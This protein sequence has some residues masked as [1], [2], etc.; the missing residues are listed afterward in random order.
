MRKI[1]LRRDGFVCTMKP[2]II[3]T[4][5]L[6][7]IST[8][9]IFAQPLCEFKP[10]SLNEGFFQSKVS[11]IIQDK[12]G[13]IW[14]GTRNGLMQFDGYRFRNYKSYP[15][16]KCPMTDYRL[17][18]I[19]ESAGG[20]I[21]CQSLDHRAYLFDVRIKKFCDVLKSVESEAKKHYKVTKIIPLKKGVTWI[22]CRGNVL[23]RVEDDLSKSGKGIIPQSGLKC[24]LRGDSI[25]GVTDDARGDEWI[26]T[27]QGIT[28]LGRKLFPVRIPFYFFL[29]TKQTIWLAS[30]K[31][32]LTRYNPVTEKL[33][34]VKLPSYVR[35]IYMLASLKSGM[36][37]I[38]TDAGLIELNP[39]T[40][41]YHCI[42]VKVNT[43]STNEVRT[44]YEDH[45]GDL[46]MFN[47]HP[48]ILHYRKSD[49]KV[50][51]LLPPVNERIKHCEPNSRIIIEDKQGI[52]WVTPKGGN[53]C[54][55]D[56]KE[57]TLKY[58]YA[59][60]ADPNSL[61]SPAIRANFFDKQGN[62]WLGANYSFGK[63][64]FYKRNYTLLPKEEDE[65]EIRTFLLDKNRKLWVASKNE[66]LKILDAN[67]RCLGYVS[68]NGTLSSTPCSFHTNVYAFLED[69]QGNI[70]LGTKNKGLYL[71]ERKT[72]D[73]YS[74]SVRH[75]MKDPADRFSLSDNKIYS[76]YQDCK[77]RIWI[78]TFRGGLNLIDREDGG[79]VRFIHSSNRLKNFPIHLA[80][81]VRSIMEVD[82]RVMLLGTM[83]GIVSFSSAFDKPE[84]IRYFV[85]SHRPDKITSL[86]NNN[87]MYMF[88]DSKK[89]I[90]ALTE[91][92]GVNKILSNNL[93]SDN[94]QFYNY[95]QKEGLI[96]DQTLSMI[97]DKAGKLWV[98]TKQA[99]Y[100][101]NPLKNEDNH[102]YN[103]TFNQDF[104]FSESSI[105][106]NAKGNVVVG[107]DKGVLE[108][109]SGKTKENIYVPPIVFTDLNIQGKPASEAIGKHNP[110]TLE[111][112]QRDIF[113]EFAALDY[114]DSKKI[115]YAY[116]MEGLDKGWHYVNQERS[117]T[118]MN[119]PHGEYK[120]LVKS[121]NSEGI[122]VDNVQNLTIRVKPTFWETGWAW[123][124]I[125][126]LIVAL[127]LIVVYILF[128][129]Y[130]LRHQV[131][132]E[133]QLSNIKLNFFTDI[134][135]ELRT[136]LTLIT[137]PVS[138]ILE[139]EPLSET[140]KEHLTI[141]RKNTDRML[142][143][144][145]Q[146][147]DFRK[148][149]YKKMKVLIEETDV[150]SFVSRIMDNFQLIAEEKKISFNLDSDREALYLWIDK[151]K[152]E[153][154]I[155]NL[156]SNAFKYTP[157][158]KSVTVRI[159]TQ[160]N[161]VS[162]SIIDEGVGILAQK[163]DSLFQRFETLV[164]QSVLH[165]SSG[166]G[167]A[168][169]KE[170]VELHHGSIEVVSQPGIGSEFKVMFL[171]G[172][173]QFDEDEE[174]NFILSDNKHSDIQQTNNPYEER[175]L[176]QM[177]SPEYS[178]VREPENNK[179]KWTILIVED[180]PELLRFMKNILSKEYNI[181][182]AINGQD[183]IE[184]ILTFMPDIVVSDV[185][186]PVMDGLDMVKAVKENKDLCHIPIIL[187]SAKS[188]LDDRIKGL[189]NG[190]D[191]YITKPFSTN[192]LKA[193]IRN[194]IIQR[195]ELQKLY[196][197][198]LSVRE[199]SFLQEQ[200]TPL[201][202]HIS[203]YDEIFIQRLMDFIEEN[204]ENSALTVED[205]ASSFAMSRSTFFKKVKMLLGVSPNDFIRDI[206]I[207]RAIRYIDSGMDSVTEVAYKCGFSDPN[208]FGKSFKKQMGV[209][210]S[211]YK[212]KSLQ[213]Q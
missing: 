3:T 119:L 111:P 189:E 106:L 57:Q 196:L 199:K 93:L 94:I 31:G 90:Y 170:L 10:Y 4:T 84:H 8:L 75:F 169:V 212:K 167:L 78:G 195:Q 130:R 18:D 150:I 7:F 64:S 66:K 213:R 193:R 120:F 104:L 91:T 17:R 138:D 131:E 98:V 185:M 14:I 60:P 45:I 102:F 147:L 149:Q 190:V 22:I 179:E 27:N 117:A 129:I 174:I 158:H 44:V 178:D 40:L 72:G 89:Q 180:N 86:S 113:I 133:H 122:W 99:L 2:H 168:L 128:T 58:Y 15:G 32:I 68:E 134:S 159:L 202:P 55:F 204:I 42:P 100:K 208:Y 70:W 123:V 173:D 79:M 85:N 56:R 141:V 155:F 53:L 192:Y 108:I 81:Q 210:P 73:K 12:K 139:N 203:T 109:H 163:I 136:P 211:E 71:L 132:M 23:F 67:N 5:F 48:G 151:D 186:M 21:W 13:L 25:Y 145:N 33:L 142:R 97:E 88:R 188:M 126:F 96:S 143:M 197:N 137:S 125:A 11:D 162:I 110:L 41:R 140:A 166:I 82:G 49:G 28:V 175:S 43:S 157:D 184:K 107:T 152:F 50:S 30:K 46:W 26:L 194:L 1:P 124:L 207:K 153:K 101:F 19:E 65:R 114:R 200:T 54:Y 83:K 156:L 112:S 59:D 92:G 164:N 201:D 187:L 38:G 69:H 116:M 35:N 20:D 63:L 80:E 205:F 121:T 183:G 77:Q 209:S 135:H 74:F 9:S 182:E 172:K 39:A 34:F 103:Y 115:Q 181:I 144:V 87:V 127:M 95:I 206:R 47:N 16:D 76:L 191:D 37:A 160:D 62:L 198:S 61:I 148:I 146:I 6:L 154:I 36:L 29:E 105:A 176:Y 171:M 51:L 118:Y 24:K 52:I 161:K 165:C 177:A